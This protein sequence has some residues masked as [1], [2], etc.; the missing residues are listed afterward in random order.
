[1]GRRTFEM[2]R[3]AANK[4]NSNTLS[5][6][7]HSRSLLNN[8]AH[9]GCVNRPISTAESN[10]TLPVA[11]R[12]A[13]AGA[14]AGAIENGLTLSCIASFCRI[15]MVLQRQHCGGL[16]TMTGGAL[17]IKEGFDVRTVDHA[18]PACP[19]RVHTSFKC[20]HSGVAHQRATERLPSLPQKARLAKLLRSWTGASS[21]HLVHT[22]KRPE[23]PPLP[24]AAG[25]CVTCKNVQSGRVCRVPSPETFCACQLQC[26]QF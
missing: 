2:S 8:G 13:R 4:S 18:V 25:C 1:M 10:A 5:L 21:Q 12:N 3:R 20:M 9:T 6:F 17:I 19:W 16:S 7:C 11:G 26:A 24:P 15:C 23:A 14:N 22:L